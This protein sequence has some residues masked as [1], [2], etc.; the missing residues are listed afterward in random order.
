VAT[1]GISIISLLS[2]GARMAPAVPTYAPRDPSQT[3]LYHVVAEH[4][5]T[6]LASCHDDPEATGLPAY[7]QR[8]SRTCW[9]RILFL[10]LSQ[11][12]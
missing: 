2:V 6:F 11:C 8:G 10:D 7:V 5:E 1:P 12:V 4:L 9:L 3:V